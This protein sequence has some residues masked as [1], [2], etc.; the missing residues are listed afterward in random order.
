MANLAKAKWCKKKHEKM[1]ET[2]AQRYSTES[3]QRELS[4]EYQHDMVKMVF[5][6]YIVL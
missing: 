4:N 2:L 1:T 6:N 3:S 5:Q